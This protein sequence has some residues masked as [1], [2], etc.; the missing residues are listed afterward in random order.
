MEPLEAHELI[1]NLH[2]Y[3]RL[4]FWQTV[5]NKLLAFLKSGRSVYYNRCM[6]RDSICLRYNVDITVNLQEKWWQ[7]Q[8]TRLDR[9]LAYKIIPVT[10]AVQSP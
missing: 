2:F 9:A 6:R 1:S 10:S 4:R 3:G 8:S 5:K 7:S